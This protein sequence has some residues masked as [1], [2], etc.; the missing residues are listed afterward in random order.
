MKLRGNWAIA[1]MK[2]IHSLI[3]KTFSEILHRDFHQITNSV[4]FYLI[5][6]DID[7]ILSL[8]NKKEKKILMISYHICM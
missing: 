4:N 3:I 5:T 1:S 7:A 8:L 6:Y 2:P